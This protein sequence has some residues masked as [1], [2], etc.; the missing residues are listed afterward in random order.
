MTHNVKTKKPIIDIKIIGVGGCGTNSAAKMINS[1]FEG[2]E[3]IFANT[4]RQALDNIGAENN[5]YLGSEINDGMGAG[6]NPEIGKSAAI[7]SEEQIRNK[8]IGSKLLIITAGMGGGTGTG[9]SPI[10]AKIAKEMGILTIAIVTTPFAFE[11]IKRDVNSQKGIEELRKTV[12]SLIIVSNNKLLE[13]YSEISFEDS[14][15]MADKILKNTVQI[16]TDII[17][18][19][20]YINLDFADV[21]S[22]I[23]DTK[24]AYIWQG[25]ASGKNKAEKAVMK[26]IN[27]NMLEN[28]INDSTDAIVNLTGGNDIS[29]SEAN[30]IMNKI[31]EQTNENI[32]IIFGI[33]KDESIKNEIQVS[34]I[35]TSGKGNIKTINPEFPNIQSSDIFKKNSSSQWN[36]DEESEKETLSKNSTDQND[37]FSVIDD[38]D[39]EIPF[40]LK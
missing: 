35:A 20:S 32:N 33:R 12:D 36:Y 2:V 10:I 3:F 24:N 26:A 1:D 17:L 6:A 11:G 18:K 13:N 25:R 8:I 30:F 29:L 14:F 31:K 16:L 28:S 22:I 4:D 21:C 34:I 40:F 15:T 19:P 38:D 37:S 27:S 5:I 7:A 9:A 39:D 23:K